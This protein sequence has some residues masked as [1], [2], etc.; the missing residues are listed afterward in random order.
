MVRSFNRELDRR[1]AAVELSPE[2]RRVIEAERVKLAGVEL[3]P[4]IGQQTR[5]ALTRAIDESFVFGFRL[6]MMTSPGLAL[7]SALVAF[8]MIETRENKS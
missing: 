4:G 1:L 5:L 7:A 8:T 6:V 3:P 2:V